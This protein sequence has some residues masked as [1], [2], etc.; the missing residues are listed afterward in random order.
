MALPGLIDKPRTDLRFGKPS[1]QAKMVDQPTASPGVSQCSTL[2]QSPKRM[3]AHPG[4]CPLHSAAAG[5]GR[6]PAAR[7]RHSS[8]VLALRD[9]KN[10]RLRHA[11]GQRSCSP[12][13]RFGVFKVFS[14]L[15]EI[16]QQANRPAL[17][18]NIWL[19]LGNSVAIAWVI[20]QWVLGIFC[21]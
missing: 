16:G 6:R 4:M 5:C 3:P 20:C 2:E 21:L 12:S 17:G 8:R 9:Q 18:Q 15:T 19:Q 10:H 13:T 14:S 1:W 11:P 7:D